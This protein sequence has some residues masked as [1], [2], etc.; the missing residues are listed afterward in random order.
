MIYDYF[1]VFQLNKRYNIRI[2]EDSLV[3]PTNHGPGVHGRNNRH[4]N[5][6]FQYNLLSTFSWIQTTN[7]SESNKIRD[8][9]AYNSFFMYNRMFHK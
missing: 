8:L 5:T 4:W 2:F 3:L 9:F 7:G 6:H 1:S